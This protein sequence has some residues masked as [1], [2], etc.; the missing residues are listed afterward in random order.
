MSEHAGEAESLKRRRLVAL[1]GYALLPALVASGCHDVGRG[2]TGELVIPRE[3]L[4][5]IEPLPLPP[6]DA[7]RQAET[8][9]AATEPVAEA[10][11]S[12]EEVRRGALA[13]NPDL[14]IELY[15]PTIARES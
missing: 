8:R 6:D 14:G 15:N 7:G 5:E 9:P 12:I 2:G 3:R 13:N 4:R 11:L 10:R 1:L